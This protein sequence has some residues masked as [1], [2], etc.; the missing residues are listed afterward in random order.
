[1]LSFMGLL[2][3]EIFAFQHG[4][5]VDCLTPCRLQT[6]FVRMRTCLSHGY[7]R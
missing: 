1:M 7:T 5:A 2:M 6:T 4:Q 3:V